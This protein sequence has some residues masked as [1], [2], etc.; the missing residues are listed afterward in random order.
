[1]LNDNINK[2][3]ESFLEEVIGMSIDNVIRQDSDTIDVF[4][5][6]RFG[7]KLELGSDSRMIYRGSPTLA[8]G[9]ISTD[10]VEMRFDSIFAI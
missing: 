5:E 2:R 4:I 9:R 8:E 1:M 3:F 6:E 10:D 7:K